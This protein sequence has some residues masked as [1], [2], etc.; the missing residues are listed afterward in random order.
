MINSI[1]KRKP[2]KIILDRLLLKD[3]TNN[4]YTFTNNPNIIETETINHFQNFASSTDST[5]YHSVQNLPTNWQ[6]IYDQLQHRNLQNKWT[7]MLKTILLEELEDTLKNLGKNKAPGP[8]GITYE[9]IIHLYKDVKTILISIYS[10]IIKLSII[11]STWREALLFPIP[12]PYDWDS[13]LVNTQPITL[14]ETTW[15]IL[16]SIYSRQLNKIL[17]TENIL[18]Y[19]NRA[20]IFGQS[21]LEPLFVIQHITEHFTKHEPNTPLWIIFQ[22]LSK[23][24][25][26]VNISLLKLAMERIYMPNSIINFFINLFTNRSNR[27]VLQDRL[28]KSYGILQGIDQ[29]EIVSPLLWNIYYDL[30]FQKINEQMD[31]HIN[32]NTK[33]IKNILHEK[34][35]I[36][37]KY[38]TSLVGYLDD[39]TWFGT[40]LDQINRK[41]SIANEFY[42]IAK[43]QINIDKYKILTND[44]TTACNL[45]QLNINNN[46]IQPQ[47]TPINNCERILG[48]YINIWNKPQHTIKKGKAIVQGHF[49]MLK[50]KKLTH[51]HIRYIINKIIIPKLEYI[52]QHT[53]VV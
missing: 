41:L 11:P 26:R 46:V 12:K 7:N 53:I 5:I 40:S 42:N 31:L 13:K 9:D 44:K 22:D 51:D 38:S 3:N 16:V 32:L 34:D 17:S 48:L 23:A 19:N 10:C 15:K 6:N 47:M 25:D 27:I 1:L 37:Y 30:I 45:I 18:Q 35:D 50:K 43:I 28:S 20:S 4:S 33:K 2:R 21:T 39:T 49:H 36:L 24:Y 8:S 29:G 14:L 52:F